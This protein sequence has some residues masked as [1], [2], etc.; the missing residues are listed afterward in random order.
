MRIYIEELAIGDDFIRDLANLAILTI[1][2]P[3]GTDDLVDFT[4]I[5]PTGNIIT[6]SSTKLVPGT[7]DIP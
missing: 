5:L 2:G 3:A 6:A 1:W 4:T 7:I